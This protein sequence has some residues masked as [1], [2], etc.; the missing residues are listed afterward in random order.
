MNK[1]DIINQIRQSMVDCEDAHPSVDVEDQAIVQRILQELQL[2]IG[3]EYEPFR[4]IEELGQYDIPGAGP[5]VAKYIRSL[6]SQM[7]RSS[8]L[9]HLLGSRAHRCARVKNCTALVWQLFL[10]FLSSDAYFDG[11]I[12]N[13]YDNAFARLKPREYSAE[14]FELSKNPYIFNS[15]P[16]TM[17]LLASW[18]LPDFQGI[19]LDY[20][21]HPQRIAEYLSEYS[22]NGQVHIDEEQIKKEINWWEHSGKYTAISGLKYYPSE[23]TAAML[24]QYAD[25]LEEEMKAERGKCADRYAKS[26]VRYRYSSL[27]KTL[28]ESILYIEKEL[29]AK[30]HS[31][32]M[33]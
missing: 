8:L 13:V 27:W 4:N 10:D 3:D 26:D 30:N 18:R 12:L 29:S 22:L 15:M 23:Q 6:K 7:A 24:K 32:G 11:S 33:K 20:F 16:A 14:L 28:R 19:L 1:I 5:I 25:N 9:H 17:D 2:K 21:T 31:G